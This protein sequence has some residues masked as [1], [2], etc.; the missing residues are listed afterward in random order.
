MGLTPEREEIRKIREWPS[1]TP[2]ERVLLDEID[3]LRPFERD[4]TKAQ[5]A[6]VMRTQERDEARADAKRYQG[7]LVKVLGMLGDR[8][9]IVMMGV[10]AFGRVERIIREHCPELK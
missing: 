1:S 3:R 6:A 4:W 5:H 7:A 10:Q 2:Q 8:Q 9:A